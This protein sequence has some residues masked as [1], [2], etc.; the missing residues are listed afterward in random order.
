MCN[1]T[2]RIDT[3]SLRVPSV[4][5]LASCYADSRVTIYQ[6]LKSQRC[7]TADVT[8]ESVALV[9]Q[10]ETTPVDQSNIVGASMG[11]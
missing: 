5:T 1:N 2:A 10:I 8:P 7:Y 4:A 3:R 11:S 6:E 9:L